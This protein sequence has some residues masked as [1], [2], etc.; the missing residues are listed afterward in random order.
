[1]VQLDSG[2]RVFVAKIYF[3][4]HSFH[5]VIRLFSGRFPGRNPPARMTI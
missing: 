2:Q 3:E 1:M 4:T 5:E